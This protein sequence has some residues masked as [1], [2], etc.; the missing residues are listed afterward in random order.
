MLPLVSLAGVLRSTLPFLLHHGGLLAGC[1][2]LPR[3]ETNEVR[4]VWEGTM[5][6]FCRFSQLQSVALSW[7]ALLVMML[8][9][10]GCLGPLLLSVRAG[11]RP[12]PSSTI[13]ALG[14][15]RV[16][17]RFRRLGGP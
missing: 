11:W 17:I 16:R 15:C 1:M 9:V 12:L 8:A 10:L 14:R 13:N 2:L 6:R 5:Q 3:Q 7:L 4:E